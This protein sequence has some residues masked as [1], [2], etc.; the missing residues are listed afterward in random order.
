MEKVICPYCKDEMIKG[1]LSGNIANLYGGHLSWLPDDAKFFDKFF[2]NNAI[3]LAEPEMFTIPN[4]AA[5]IC[6][7][8]NKMIINRKIIRK[9]Y[10][11]NKLE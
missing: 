3:K 10:M 8:C 2:G 9:I 11:K 1:K 7:N 4:I 5:Y 6:K